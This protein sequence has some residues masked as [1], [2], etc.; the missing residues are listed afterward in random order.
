MLFHLL[1]LF[2]TVQ[3]VFC[4]NLCPILTSGPANISN[5]DSIDVQFIQLDREIG[6]TT[7]SVEMGRILQHKT[8]E[9][10][11]FYKR[12]QT[13][14]FAK[15]DGKKWLLFDF[16]KFFNLIDTIACG[17]MGNTTESSLRFMFNLYVNSIFHCN[18][19]PKL[20]GKITPMSNYMIPSRKEDYFLKYIRKVH[21]NMLRSEWLDLKKASTT[22]VSCSQFEILLACGKG[23]AEKSKMKLKYAIIFISI[24][25]IIFIVFLFMFYF[26]DSIV[27]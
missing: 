23:D 10:T 2:F 8:I 15:D 26:K 24:V 18:I 13:K 19:N 1:F 6:I 17:S 16:E 14:T 25:S 9:Q 3:K 4:E 5:F 20:V 11:C 22:S 27:G 12:N 21:T 7:I